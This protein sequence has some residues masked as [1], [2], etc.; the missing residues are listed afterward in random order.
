MKLERG[1]VYLCSLSNT[2]SWDEE[3]LEY[4]D[5][6]EVKLRY[7]NIPNRKWEQTDGESVDDLWEVEALEEIDEDELNN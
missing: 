4:M 5:V 2:D 3:E 1:K 7:V 6:I